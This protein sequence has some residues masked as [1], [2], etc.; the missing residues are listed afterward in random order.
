MK[1][2]QSYSTFSVSHSIYPLF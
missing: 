1:D 2:R